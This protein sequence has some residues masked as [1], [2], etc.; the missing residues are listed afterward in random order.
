M[1]DLELALEKHKYVVQPGGK[2]QVNITTISKLMDIDGKSSAFAG[3][4]VKITKAGG[5]Y[6]RE[7]KESGELGTRVHGYCENFLRG[8][9]IDYRSGE[10]EGYVEALEKFITEADPKV[11]DLEFVVVSALG[12]GGRGDMLVEIDGETWLIDLKSGKRY[13]YEHTLQLAALRY[14]RRAQYDGHGMLSST[15]PM[16][17]ID[18][19]A[20]LYVE[21]NGSYELVEYPADK[22]AF[23]AFVCL[24][25]AYQW[26]RLPQIHELANK[27]RA[28]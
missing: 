4:A 22:R 25:T 13:A 11:I 7:W 17:E 9:A 28:A 16:P 24:L 1:T 3:S 18:R 20:A 15:E 10:E 19:T 14:A 2:P 12:Y 26:T 5:D 8:E 6:R 21:N 27:W 23:Q